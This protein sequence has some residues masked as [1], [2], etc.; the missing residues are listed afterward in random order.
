MDKRMKNIKQ[1]NMT[2][3]KKKTENNKTD[4]EVSK[5]YSKQKQKN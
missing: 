2:C 5:E 3:E 1:N 4:Q